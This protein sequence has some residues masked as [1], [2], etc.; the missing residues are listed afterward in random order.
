MVL[1]FSE[2]RGHFWRCSKFPYCRNLITYQPLDDAINISRLDSPEKHKE[3]LMKLDS[4]S[5]AKNMI[6]FQ[7]QME[8]A[9]RHFIWCNLHYVISFV[10]IREYFDNPVL[11]KQILKSDVIHEYKNNTIIGD[12]GARIFYDLFFWLMNVNS[13]KVRNYLV[14]N[15]PQYWDQYRNSANK[16]LDYIYNNERGLRYLS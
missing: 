16:T 3:Q 7:V 14:E 15:F 2:Q 6:D 4:K 1:R 5:Y 10:Y 9:L 8:E 11:L 13:I 12:D